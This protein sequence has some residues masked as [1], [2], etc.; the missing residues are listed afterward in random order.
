LHARRS[1]GILLLQ[2]SDALLQSHRVELIDFEHSNAALG[3]SRTA[4]QPFP[5]ALRRIGK[6]SIY[7]LYEFLVSGRKPHRGRHC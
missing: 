6:S 4:Q 7:D 1:F 2:F 5:A 3:A